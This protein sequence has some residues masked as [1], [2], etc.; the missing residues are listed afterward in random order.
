MLI[1]CFAAVFTAIVL[2]RA[3]KFHRGSAEA[4]DNP[5]FFTLFDGVSVFEPLEVHIRSVLNFT[6][7]LGKVANVDLHRDESVPEHRFH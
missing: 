3:Q 2:V 6:F 4:A 1:R 7:K 5:I